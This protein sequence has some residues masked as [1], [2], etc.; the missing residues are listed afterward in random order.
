MTLTVNG[1]I[2]RNSG[3]DARFDLELPLNGV[4]AILGPSGAGKSTLL[5]A[6]AGFEP[7]SKLQIVVD[8]LEAKTIRFADEFE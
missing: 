4:T 2:A 3:F 6:I 1:T 7:G 5:R 8:G